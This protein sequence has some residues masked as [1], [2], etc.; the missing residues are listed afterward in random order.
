VARR[1]DGERQRW[2]E[3]QELKLKEKD[4]QLGDLRKALEDATRRSERGSQERQRE[5]LDIDVEAELARRF[6]QDAILPV[7]KG[8]RGADDIVHEV[9]DRAMRVCGTIVW[10]ARNARHCQR[11]WRDKVKED[12]RAVGANLAVII[13]T[14]FPD[15]IVE[16]RLCRWG[17]GRRPARLA[18]SGR[19]LARAADPGRLR[20]C[21]RGGQAREDG[22]SLRLSRSRTT[23]SRAASRQRSRPSPRCA[24]D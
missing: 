21:R 24:T 11:G 22:G 20:A 9:R 5:V 4:K 12:Q 13:S 1:V 15:G 17:L 16:F 2:S 23:S 6:P 10:E 7:A 8:A 3:Q 18:G 14:V 19:G